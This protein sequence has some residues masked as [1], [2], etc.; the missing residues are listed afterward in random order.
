MALKRAPGF[1]LVEVVIAAAVAGVVSLLAASLTLQIVR[2]NSQVTARAAVTRDARVSLGVIQRELSQARGHTVVID[3][4]DADQPPYSSA[5]FTTID[6]HDVCYYQRGSRLYRRVVKGAA[7]STAIVAAGLRQALFSYP[8]SDAT[9][10]LSVALTFEQAT[11]GGQRKSLS[12]SSSKIR[13]Q[14]PDAF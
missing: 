1:T 8:M 9:G 4:Y 12:L 3:R 11:Y 5:A 14:N 2:F 10:L 7:I 13:I 6:G